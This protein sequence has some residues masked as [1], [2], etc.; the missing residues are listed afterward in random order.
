MVNVIHDIS[1]DTGGLDYDAVDVRVNPRT[2][3]V[4][5]H[6]LL[7]EIR[8]DVESFQLMLTI[9]PT[10]ADVFPGAIT[11]ATVFISDLDGKAPSYRTGLLWWSAQSL[12]SEHCVR[13]SGMYVL[14]PY[15]AFS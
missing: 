10:A 2:E 11:T 1:H 14:R 7:D 12:Y 13:M 9:P 6:V 8:E 15:S 5:V 3:T 4:T